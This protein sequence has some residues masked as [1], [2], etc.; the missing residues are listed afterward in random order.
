MACEEKGVPCEIVPARPHTPDI[1]APHPLGKI[2]GMRRPRPA[3]RSDSAGL[4][5]AR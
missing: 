2:P 4:L 5:A 3:T 1:D